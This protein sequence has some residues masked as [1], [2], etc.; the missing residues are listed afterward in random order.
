MMCVRWF[1]VV[2]A[3]AWMCAGMA[4]ADEADL[5][6]A[7]E[8]S[9]KVAQRC[10]EA[11]LVR[12]PGLEGSVS[13]ALV[14]D[15][16]GNVG[17]VSLEADRLGNTAVT[18]CLLK[19]LKQF[20]LGQASANQNTVMPYA[21]SHRTRTLAVLP[22]ENLTGD[23]KQDW[24]RGATAEVLMVKLGQLKS[25]A[26]VDRIRLA[27][28]LK[29]QA[30]GQSGGVDVK[31]ASQAG[32]LMGA[33]YLVMG[34]VQK[35]GDKIRLTSRLVDAQSAV[36]KGTADVVGKLDD[37]FDLQDALAR[38]LATAMNVMLDGDNT[39]ALEIRVTTSMAELALLGN[40][41]NAAANGDRE[42][43]LAQFRELVAL[44][45]KLPEAHLGVARCALMGKNS[46][47]DLSEARN[48]ADAALLLRPNDF[49]ALHWRG[50]VAY[51]QQKPDEAME[52]QRKAVLIKPNHPQGLYGLGIAYSAQGK[53]D[54][55][56][57]Y[58]ARA[59][60]LD[61]EQEE[62]LTQ[63]SLIES[64]LKGDHAKAVAHSSASMALPDP[65]V[66][67]VGVHAGNQFRAGNY[68]GCLATLADAHARMPTSSGW[69]RWGLMTTLV[70]ASCL[71][72]DGRKAEAQRLVKGISDNQRRALKGK[73][74]DALAAKEF[75]LYLSTLGL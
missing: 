31:T 55:A 27:E 59:H 18:A 37:V 32:Q 15:K 30:F 16:D 25:V 54:E 34:N 38:A 7:L 3:P 21:F 12:E 56:L 24:M 13:V 73:P 48:A 35:A 2:T 26:V 58:V 75:G 71:T 62:Y 63:L 57:A 44:N 60:A 41:E 8:P 67:T 29:E 17:S 4:R 28:V 66:W 52:W 11:E 33:Q 42:V 10:Y 22:F 46:G 74:A 6:R 51:K 70:E 61:P 43:A 69:K 40:A 68:K 39:R 72:R 23:P 64:V 5:Q 36:I 49:D 9:L 53:T 65:T 45:P 14:T 20:R 50:L 47:D 1:W 19:E